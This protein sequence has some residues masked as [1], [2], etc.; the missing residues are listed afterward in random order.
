MIEE[1]FEPEA[2]PVQA[3]AVFGERIDLARGYAAALVR[4]S[5]LLGLLGPREM[6]RLWSRHILN[7]AVVAELVAPGKTVC[8]IGSGAGLPGIPMAIV[9]PDTRF[10]LIEPMERRSDW[11]IS[12]VEEL[13]LTNVEVLRTRAEEVGEAF[14]IAT[15]RAVSALPKLLRLC[16]PL[17]RHGG[18]ILA[19]KGSKAAEEIEDAKRIQKKMGI[20]SFEIVHAGAGLLTEPTLVVRTKLV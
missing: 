19:L 15:A 12:V 9:L 1:V 3:A 4:D 6:P 8:D 14:D 20:S 10:T 17:V 5:D 11:L 13:G 16:V 2:E 18:E 7:S